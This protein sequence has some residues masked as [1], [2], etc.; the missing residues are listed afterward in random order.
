MNNCTNE[1]YKEYKQYFIICSTE[2]DNIVKRRSDTQKFT[3]FP[4]SCRIENKEDE[5]KK[6]EGKTEKDPWFNNLQKE[7]SGFRNSLGS[8]L[9]DIYY[10]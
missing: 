6:L 7:I 8:S 5:S 4:Y 3:T 2:L 10:I 1:E 9:I